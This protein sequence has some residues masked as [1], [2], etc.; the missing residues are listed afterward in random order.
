[1]LTIDALNTLDED[2][3]VIV[4]TELSKYADNIC[5]ANAANVEFN[6]QQSTES[7][8]E[9]KASFPVW[10]MT[11]IGNAAYMSLHSPPEYRQYWRN[12]LMTYIQWVSER[13]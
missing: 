5:A 10:N 1:M 2:Q 11:S 3:I 9:V 12:I 7:I 6:Q 13:K 4:Y 8:E